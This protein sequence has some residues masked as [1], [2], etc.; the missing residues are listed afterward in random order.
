MMHWLCY[1]LGHKHI[2]HS[3]ETVWYHPDYCL[4]CNASTA[5]VRGDGCLRCEI[6]GHH[7]KASISGDSGG[8]LFRTSWCQRCH[9]APAAYLAKAKA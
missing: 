5:T 6:F 1:I 3:F 9:A 2:G 4:R 8:W 7:H